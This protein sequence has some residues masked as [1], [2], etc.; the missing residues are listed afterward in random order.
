MNDLAPVLFLLLAVLGAFVVFVVMMIQ[1]V[2][3]LEKKKRKIRGRC[4][5][6]TVLLQAWCNAHP[7]EN[8]DNQDVK[9]LVVEALAA[10]V[11]F[12]GLFG[13][14][15]DQNTEYLRSLLWEKNKVPF[16]KLYVV[17]NSP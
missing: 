8:T 6:A 12:Q 7:N 1:Y 17:V 5:Y 16:Q 15:Y 4:A 9:K 14:E 3:F 10:R 2:F 13:K 11:M